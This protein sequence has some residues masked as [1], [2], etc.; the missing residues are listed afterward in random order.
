MNM[1]SGEYFDTYDQTEEMPVT[2][3]DF[4]DAQIVEEMKA[5]RRSST[6]SMQALNAVLDAETLREV[7]RMQAVLNLTGNGIS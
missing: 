2:W 5:V 7:I 3:Q 6:V 1:R 4:Q